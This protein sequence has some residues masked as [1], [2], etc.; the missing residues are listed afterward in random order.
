MRKELILNKYLFFM[1]IMMNKYAVF[2]YAAS[3]SKK[4]NDF[5]LKPFAK[6][7]GFEPEIFG[8]I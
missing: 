3:K 5:S 1:T 4:S 2:C 6:D 8:A 7:G